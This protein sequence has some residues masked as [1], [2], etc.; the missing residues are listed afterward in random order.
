MRGPRWITG[1]KRLMTVGLN[2]LC[3]A[4][5]SSNREVEKLIGCLRSSR[6]CRRIRVTTLRKS[7][8]LLRWLTS[9]VRKRNVF[10][11]KGPGL[12]GCETAMP[13]LISS[14]N[15]RYNDERG[16]MC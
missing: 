11:F 16:I 7:R 12:T 10:G 15:I 4:G 13:I 1:L 2:S 8:Q 6:S 14:I 3:G 9:Y 5:K